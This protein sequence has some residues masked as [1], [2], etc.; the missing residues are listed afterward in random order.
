MRLIGT[1]AARIDGRDKVRGESRYGA[2]Q[3]LPSLLH[4]RLQLSPH[5]RARITSVD[6]A[7]AR[8]ISGVVA[9]FTGEDLRFGTGR[10]GLVASEVVRYAGQPVVVAVAESESAA[11]DAVA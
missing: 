8:S 10:E 11:A 3:Q 6:L 2:D 1:P 5:A 4:A 7:P 9:V